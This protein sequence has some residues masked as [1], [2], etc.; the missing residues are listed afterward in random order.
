MMRCQL[1]QMNYIYG[2]NAFLPYSAGCLQA[3]CVDNEQVRSKVEFD[4]LEDYAREVV[5]YGRKGTAMEYELE[6]TK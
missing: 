6:V 5:W 4:T 3:A 1:I 2:D